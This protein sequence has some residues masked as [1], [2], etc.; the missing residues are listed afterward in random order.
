MSDTNALKRQLDQ[1]LDELP[2]EQL[3]E[4]LDFARSLVRR[5]P[6]DGPSIEQKIEARLARVPDE[7]L[8]ELPSDASENL[9][10]Y[11]YGAPKR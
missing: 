3:R 11:L 4:V 9:D 10:H 8:D 6:L 7:V 5:Q 1:Q 2:E